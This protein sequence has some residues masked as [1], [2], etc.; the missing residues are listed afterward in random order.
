MRD[1][2]ELGVGVVTLVAGGGRGGSKNALAGPG[3]DRFAAVE[4]CVK[5]G[6]E[7]GEVERGGAVPVAMAGAVG[8]VRFGAVEVVGVHE[9]DVV[10]QG[11]AVVVGRGEDGVEV[12][13]DGGFAGGGTAAETEDEGVGDGIGGG[14][15]WGGVRGGEGDGKGREL[16]VENYIVF[17]RLKVP[18]DFN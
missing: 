5:R 1:G 17:I 6:A 3:G 12:G 2:G 7:R 18:G 14:G 15:H 8:Q 4:P 16:K 13:G 10:A 9:G 11:R